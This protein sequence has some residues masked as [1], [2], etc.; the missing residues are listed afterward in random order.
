MYQMSCDYEV[1]SISGLKFGCLNAFSGQAT[2]LANERGQLLPRQGEMG[3]NTPFTRKST[4]EP[5]KTLERVTTLRFP[6]Y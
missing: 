5:S 3:E 2:K 1:H 4:S 6:E